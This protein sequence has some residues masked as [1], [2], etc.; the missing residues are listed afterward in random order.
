MPIIPNVKGKLNSQIPAENKRTTRRSRNK[1]DGRGNNLLDLSIRAI[2][3]NIVFNKKEQWAYFKISNMPYSFR[4]YDDKC[5]TNRDIT[6]GFESLMADRNQEIE[7]HLIHA[8]VPLDIDAWYEDEMNA[9]AAHFPDNSGIERL[10]PGGESYIRDMRNFLKET[11]ASRK[12]TF[13]GIKLG[14]RSEKTN[15]DSM[16]IL[17]GGLQDGFRQITNAVNKALSFANPDELVVSNEESKIAHSIEEEYFMTLSESYFNAE[18]CTPEDILLIFKR[19]MYPYMVTPYIEVNDTERVGLS[20]IVIETGHSIVKQPRWLEITQVLG[21]QQYTGYRACFTFREFPKEMKFPGSVEFFNVPESMG[22]ESTS[23]A[24]F[25]LHPTE[26]VEAQLDIKQKLMEDEMENIAMSSKSH[27]DAVT[28]SPIPKHTQEGLSDIRSLQDITYNEK[29]AWV[30][31][32][33]HISVEAETPEDL[34]KQ[35]SQLKQSFARRQ[36]KLFWSAGDQVALFLEEMPGDRR[37]VSAFDQTTT[38]SAL[39]GS[40]GFYSSDVGDDI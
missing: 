3:E 22:I 25:I 17:T 39:A 27:A 28:G 12:V 24:R 38:A 26:E 33:F 40:G 4:S 30:E 20:D 23:W 21:G 13:L 15:F 7:C 32:S 9:I 16:S 35:F 1:T 29:T 19:M 34:M 8:T 37:R 18:R 36:I 31:G 5:M 14:S 10:P 11:E 6:S 2:E